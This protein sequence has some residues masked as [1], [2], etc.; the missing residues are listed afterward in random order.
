MKGLFLGA[1][2]LLGTGLSAQTI[3]T[4]AGGGTSGLG[5]GGAA[6]LAAFGYTNGLAIDDTGNLY[7][8]D[9][10][11]HRVRKVSSATGIINTI[12]GNGLAG[13]TGDGSDALAAQLNSPQHIAVDSHGNIYISDVGNRK[14]RKITVSTG[15]I[16]TFAGDG[17]VG[18]SGDGGP[19]IL[20]SLYTPL[21]INFDKHDNLYIS[22]LGGQRIRKINV[23]GM[24]TTVAGNGFPG[25][26][27]DGNLATLAQ[28]NSPRDVTIDTAGNF[29]IADGNNNKVR[30]VDIATGI[31]TT[32]AGNATGGYSGDGIPATSSGLAGPWGVAFD[33]ENNLFIA[34][35]SNHR[36][37]KVDNFGIIS[38]VAGL[39]TAG[40]SGDGG[41]ATAAKFYNPEG[42]RIDLCDNLFVVDQ[43]NKRIRKVTFNP[44]TTPTVTITGITTASIGAT[45][46]V[47][48]AVTGISSGYSIKWFKN[49][50]LFSTT[51]APTTTYI[52][53]AGTDT[54]TAR[55]V[56]AVSYCYDSAT[57]APHLVATSWAGID[58]INIP[59]I[60][61]SIYPN[62][63]HDALTLTISATGSIRTAIVTNLL[64]QSFPDLPINIDGANARINV[65]Q[66]PPGVYVVRV[67]DVHFKR[68]LKK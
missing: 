33:S 24:I 61:L 18:S 52:K 46:T 23:F 14:I 7:I 19:A 28:L 42:V 38:T 30:R 49:S 39:G 63:V 8:A 60:S 1:A 2:L 65:T 12:S 21:G 4:A 51:A 9:Q 50:T 53:G 56:P 34:D 40:F 5:D 29:F 35:K 54:V 17:T 25:F 13:S 32:Y 64:G 16:T 20:A 27:G 43:V 44:H 11:N 22:D 57:S 31:I 48:A 55:I 3:T 58:N 47:N 41:D 36:V 45:V 26:S 6:T 67:N 62:P 15:I 59:S 10:N 37:R 66:L 68:F